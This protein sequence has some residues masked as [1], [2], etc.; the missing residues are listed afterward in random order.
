MSKNKINEMFSLSLRMGKHMTKNEADRLTE[1]ISDD[2]VI[3]NIDSFSSD[4]MEN[5]NRDYR[6]F[7][8][9]YVYGNPLIKEGKQYIKETYGQIFDADDVIKHLRGTYHFADEQFYKVEAFNGIAIYLLIAD[10]GEN[11]DLIVN[12]M[13]KMGYFLSVEKPLEKDGHTLL[14]MRF[15]PITQKDETETIKKENKYFYHFTPSE[16]VPSIMTTGLTPRNDNMFFS[17][18]PRIYLVKSNVTMND[19][20]DLGE[21]LSLKNLKDGIKGK[22]TLLGIHTDRL[23]DTVHLFFDP[24]YEH[25][26]FTT[27]TI[28]NN[29]IQVGQEYQFRYNH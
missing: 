23:P 19:L 24:N 11:H 20:Y 22:Y 4:L 9:N 18:P 6:D 1:A 8:Q 14:Q 17:Y 12:D 7:G 25:G 27:D 13:S 29:C 5:I 16:N 2:A 10:I 26:V 15:E 3:F 28:P 21:D